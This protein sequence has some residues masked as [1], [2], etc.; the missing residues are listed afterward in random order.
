MNEALRNLALKMR[1]TAD[2]T[3]FG[4]ARVGSIPRVLL[5]TPITLPLIFWAAV[6]DIA[7]RQKH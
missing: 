3:M 4:K 1:K 7:S 6:L 5:T 2:R